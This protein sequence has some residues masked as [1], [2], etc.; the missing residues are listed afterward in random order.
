MPFNKKTKNDFDLAA[1]GYAP[2]M[3][4]STPVHKTVFDQGEK[5]IG[6]FI[7]HLIQARAE[8]FDLSLNINIYNEH[9]PLLAVGID[10]DLTETSCRLSPERLMRTQRAMTMFATDIRQIDEIISDRIDHNSINVIDRNILSIHDLLLHGHV[11]SF[12]TLVRETGSYYAGLHIHG[13][14]SD[15]LQDQMLGLASMGIEGLEPQERTLQL[16]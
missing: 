3:I 8:T 9:S 7:A 12:L 4:A 13:K 1:L 16:N 2:E 11:M 5:M 6:Q 15:F 14:R 10:I